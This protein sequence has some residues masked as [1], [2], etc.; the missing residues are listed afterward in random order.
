MHILNFLDTF[1]MGVTVNTL[2][3]NPKHPNADSVE[4]F[5]PIATANFKL[6]V[7]SKIIAD[8]LATI[9]P[10]II[11]NNK[12]RFHQRKK[13]QRLLMSC[14]RSNQYLSQESL[15]GNLALK[16]DIT[17]DFDTLDWSFLLKFSVGLA[18]ITLF[19][20]E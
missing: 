6:K 9:V 15:G 8:R 12:K 17:K 7:I 5:R 3:L 13:Y 4:Q 2:I 1:S 10:T 16:I 11:S 19:E 18:L 14:F 20:S